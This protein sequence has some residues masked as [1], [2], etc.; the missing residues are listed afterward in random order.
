MR[1]IFILLALS[2]LTSCQSSQVDTSD[3]F[4]T[5]QQLLQSEKYDEAAKY[6][7]DKPN[8]KN[9]YWALPTILQ[10]KKCSISIDS[11]DKN[12][13]NLQSV[14]KCHLQIEKSCPDRHL[15]DTVENK[16]NAQIN[17]NEELEK[18][19]KPAAIYQ[20]QCEAGSRWGYEV[21]TTPKSCIMCASS[22]SINWANVTG[23]FLEKSSC[24]EARILANENSKF[25][26]SNQCYNRY[27]G[28]DKL[29]SLWKTKAM[30]M[31]RPQSFDIVQDSF[32]LYF[33]SLEKCEKAV[34]EG[35]NYSVL[36]TESEIVFG[37]FGSTN[38]NRFIK[39]CTQIQQ[40]IC[41]KNKN[42]IEQLPEQIL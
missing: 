4:Q 21:T 32:E 1:P 28:D 25:V 9:T 23:E 31:D 17:K 11:C 34:T 7:E 16:K 27:L 38:K 40:P 12:L 5:V 19:F 42:V 3:P 8:F 6:L 37:S 30:H 10:S 15:S 39:K 2:A 14:L 29:I 36:N 18:N 26:Y 24:E 13:A 20:K 35:F 22:L 41:I 33:D